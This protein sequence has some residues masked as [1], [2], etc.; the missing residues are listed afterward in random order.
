[1]PILSPEASNKKRKQFWLIACNF[2]LA[3]FAFGSGLDSAWAAEPNKNFHYSKQGCL[4]RQRSAMV[5][6]ME[7][8][9]NRQ[10]LR[11]DLTDKALSIVMRKPDWQ[12][13]MLNH[14][15]KSYFQSTLVGWQPAASMN[16]VLVRPDDPSGLTVQN[17]SPD[18][19]DEIPVLVYQMRGVNNRGKKDKF[20]RIQIKSGTIWV[21]DDSNLPAQVGEKLNHFIGAPPLHGLTVRFVILNNKGQRKEEVRLIATE[22]KVVNDSILKVPQGYTKAAKQADIFKDNC[23]SDVL[24]GLFHE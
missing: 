12:V 21:L 4:F 17:C 23:T 6:H 11:L 8:L 13:T 14:K 19:L 20:S 9:V 10:G 16:A 24:D 22:S 5:G 7:L 1:M 2:L 18:K 15:T 3:L